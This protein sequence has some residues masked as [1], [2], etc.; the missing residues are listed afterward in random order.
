MEKSQ[1][2][3][4][5]Y[6]ENYFRDQNIDKAYAK[7]TFLMNG[8]KISVQRVVGKVE[9]MLSYAGGL[10]SIIIA[11]LAFFMMSF[12]EYKYELMVAEGAFNQNEQGRK[13]LKQDLTFPKYIKY[14]VYDWVNVLCCFELQW[15]DCREIDEAR[16]EANCVMDVTRVFRKLRTFQVCLLH[17]IPQN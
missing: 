10:F 12:N 11:F 9:E 15:E 13:I 16:E 14:S 7:V 6:K 17:L 4:I 2:F 1:Y 3:D 5:F 8:E